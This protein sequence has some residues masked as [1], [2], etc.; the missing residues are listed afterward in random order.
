MGSLL[1]SQKVKTR[2]TPGT[3]AMNLELGRSL[4]ESPVISSPVSHFYSD[5]FD[6]RGT[7]RSEDREG[8]VNV[9][10][11]DGFDNILPLFLHWFILFVLYNCNDRK[12]PGFA[13]HHQEPRVLLP[14]YPGSNSSL[15]PP[16][17]SHTSSLT[18]SQKSK[19]IPLNSIPKTDTSRQVQFNLL[20]A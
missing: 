1:F 8:W 10:E 2:K 20:S 11:G 18:A 5:Y 13:S 12:K 19:C 6:K 16:L 4:G 7:F 3:S 9:Y 14:S 17:R 15:I